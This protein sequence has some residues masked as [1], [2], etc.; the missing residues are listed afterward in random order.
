MDVLVINGNPYYRSVWTDGQIN[1]T[2][3]LTSR[4]SR[5]VHQ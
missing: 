2:L 1:P 4:E 3:A 5:T